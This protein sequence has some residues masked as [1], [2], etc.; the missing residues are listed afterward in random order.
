MSESENKKGFSGLSSLESNVE[1]IAEDPTQRISPPPVSTIAPVAP[2]SSAS[3]PPPVSIVVARVPD[4]PAIV[5]LKKYW[6]WIGIGL[7]ITYSVMNSNGTS[8][9]GSGSSSSLHESL[10]AIGAGQ[11]LNASE[12]YYC[13][14]ESARIEKN[15]EILNHYDSSSISR[16]NN[17]ISSYNDRCSNYRYK[18][19]AMSAATKAFND[20]L[21]LIES[22][23]RARN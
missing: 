17:S 19:S 16:F 21:Y 13:L 6:L 15:Q 11:T 10:P 3:K 20:N 1:K 7:F 4:A 12:I 8:S 2:A 9:S 5:F 22:Q 14:A 23:G 18:K